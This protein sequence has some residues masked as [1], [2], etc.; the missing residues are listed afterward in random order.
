M[1]GRH[2]SDEPFAW[3]PFITL[4]VAVIPASLAIWTSHTPPPNPIP[5]VQIVP[6]PFTTSAYRVVQPAALVTR[7]PPINGYRGLS[8]RAKDLAAYVQKT[9]PDVKS[10]G[11]VR[12]CDAVG[13]H[14]R[15]VALDVMVGADH[16]LGDRIAFDLLGRDGVQ[17]LIWRETYRKPN[18]VSRWMPDRGSDTANHHDH[19]HVR[20][21]G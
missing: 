20:V 10:I 7:V 3:A 14:C 13:E 21:V 19:I 5:T 6:A 2:R 9:Y 18:G 1:T 8:R 4:A 11:G 16:A 17:Y 15:G 12:P